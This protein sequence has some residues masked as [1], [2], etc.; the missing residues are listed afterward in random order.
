MAPNTVQD[1]KNP[2]FIPISSENLL[3]WVIFFYADVSFFNSVPKEHIKCFSTDGIN[4][5]LNSSEKDAFSMLH[6]NIRSLK[7][8]FENLRTF[9]AKL[10]FGFQIICL[11]ETDLLLTLTT[12]ISMNCQE[13]TLVCIK[14]G[15]MERG[16]GI[17]IF[18]NGSL[19]FCFNLLRLV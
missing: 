11:T 15:I 14:L 3:E 7:R 1:L 17:C 16:I 19:I 13:V 6:I 5:E 9:L 18:L 4:L 2:R 8:N 10:G 12:K